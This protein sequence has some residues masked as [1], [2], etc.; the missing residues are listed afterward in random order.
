M[1]SIGD[2]L[3]VTALLILTPFVMIVALICD[4][5]FGIRKTLR[6]RRK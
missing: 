1:T 5:W 3:R 2:F 6:E 4:R